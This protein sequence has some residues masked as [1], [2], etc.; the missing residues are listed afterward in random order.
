MKFS[1][2]LVTVIFATLCALPVAAQKISAD[3]TA[4][5]LTGGEFLAAVQSAANVKI[6]PSQLLTYVRSNLSAVNSQTGT[7]YTVAASDIGKLVSH[8]NASSVAV[9]LPQATGLFGSGWYIYYQN[10]GAGTVTITPTTST[11]GGAATLVLTTGQG[12]A[13]FSDGINYF[14]MRSN[15]SA[16][17]SA[18][19]GGTLTSA[20]NEAPIATLSSAATVNIGATAANTIIISGVTTITAFDTINAGAVRRVKFSSS[21]TLMYDAVRMILPTLANIVTA[22]GDTAEFLSQ[23]GGNWYCLWYQRA[24]GFSLAAPGGSLTNFTESNN[25]AAPNAT[26]PVV[27]FT[28]TNAAA[29]VDVAIVPKGIGGLAL[30]VADGATNGNK[31]GTGAI[32]LL[33][34]QFGTTNVASGVNSG[35]FAGSANKATNL[36]AVVLGGS[37]NQA[38]SQDSFVGSGNIN[39]VNSPYGAIV[40]GSNNTVSGSGGS[41]ILGGDSN[42]ASG[43][44]GSVVIGGSFNTA[45]GVNSIAYGTRATTRTMIGSR[46]MSSAP[47]STF[48]VG[49]RQMREATMQQSTSGATSTVLTVDA[50]AAGAVNQFVLVSDSAMQLKGRLIVRNTTSGDVGSFDIIILARN[51]AGTVTIVSSTIGAFVG[52]VAL[53]TCAVTVSADNTNK[54]AQIS[55]TGLASTSLIWLGKFVSIELVS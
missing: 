30:R 43:N 52:D 21:L 45:N 46:A 22:S 24:S 35:L 49:A 55:V 47:N 14:A 12:V 41:L 29:D 37:N 1:M 48:T 31:R 28:A 15:T 44:G 51:V 53:N 5:T 50:A 6:L 42:N 11:I 54:A 4:A 38:N 39:I 16:S 2:R 17:G 26:I 19:T 25:S 13:I 3:P 27:S 32:D 20:L 34:S 10:T 40:G 7:S 9:N 36:R 33:S 23:G 8:S 18:F